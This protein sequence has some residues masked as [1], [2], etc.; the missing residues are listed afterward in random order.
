MARTKQTNASG[1][2]KQTSGTKRELAAVAGTGAATAPAASKAT[3]SS[4]EP[5]SAKL[6]CSNCNIYYNNAV[7]LQA[8]LKDR[9]VMYTGMKNDLTKDCDDLQDKVKKTMALLVRAKEAWRTTAAVARDLTR[10]LADAKEAQSQAALELRIEKH[11][12]LRLT[13]ELAA[14]R[15]SAELP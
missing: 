5:P 1:T 9:V 11:K 15:D 10:Q 13:A 2:S 4:A 8:Q 7:R 6:Q 12:T 14:L 3:R